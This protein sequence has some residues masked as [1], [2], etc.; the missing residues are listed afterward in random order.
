MIGTCIP[1]DAWERELKFVHVLKHWTELTFRQK[2]NDIEVRFLP[3]SQYYFLHGYSKIRTAVWSVPPKSDAIDCSCELLCENW[4]RRIFTYYYFVKWDR[5]GFVH[6]PLASRFEIISDLNICVQSCE[7][8]A[9]Y[10]KEYGHL[11]RSPVSRQRAQQLWAHCLEN[12]CWQ[13]T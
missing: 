5:V 3:N 8:S 7:C 13:Q 11:C 4:V 10:G 12:I 2:L 9:F 6:T 1:N